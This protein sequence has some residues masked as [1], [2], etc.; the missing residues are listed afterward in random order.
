[1]PWQE[2]NAA[3]FERFRLDRIDASSRDQDHRAVVSNGL[4][5]V[6]VCR[7]PNQLCTDRGAV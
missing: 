2:I 6:Q 7:F 3:A 1:V 5:E 4:T